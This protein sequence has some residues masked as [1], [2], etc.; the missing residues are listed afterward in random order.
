MLVRDAAAEKEFDMTMQMT[1]E[2]VQGRDPSKAEIDKKV[3]NT[4]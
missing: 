1:L 2:H 4:T 3:A